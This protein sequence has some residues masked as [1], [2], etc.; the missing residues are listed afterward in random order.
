MQCF[1]TISGLLGSMFQ[2]LAVESPEPDAR[3]SS[4]GFQA[5][6]KT[7]E[8]WPLR[9]QTCNGA[10]SAIDQLKNIGKVLK[11]QLSSLVWPGDCEMIAWRRLCTPLVLIVS[12]ASSKRNVANGHR[13]YEKI[14]I[15]DLLVDAKNNGGSWD[16][17][18]AVFL[19]SWNR[20]SRVF[21]AQ[22]VNQ[23]D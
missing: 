13:K 19:G 20:S 21:R 1:R 12:Q 2:I 6:M 15:R 16:Q 17:I 10:K 23:D 9:T 7:S 3:R 5:Q 11:W 4:R 22:K 18:L 14:F 8:S